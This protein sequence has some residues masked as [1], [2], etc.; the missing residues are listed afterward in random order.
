MAKIAEMQ[1]VSLDLLRLVNLHPNSTDEAL[2]LRGQLKTH[3]GGNRVWVK[4]IGL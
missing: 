1:E 4:E 2:A 3:L